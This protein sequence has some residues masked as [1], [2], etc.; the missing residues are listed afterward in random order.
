MFL[1]KSMKVFLKYALVA[2]ST[3]VIGL[4]MYLVAPSLASSSI[5]T[6]EF[7]PYAPIAVDTE[8][9]CRPNTIYVTKDY[10]GWSDNEILDVRCFEL[11]KNL[12]EAASDGDAG[13]ISALIAKGA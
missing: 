8:K 12:V 6:G 10:A 4:S 9:Q 7:P 11:Q 5:D 3:L 13:R 1:D 2:V